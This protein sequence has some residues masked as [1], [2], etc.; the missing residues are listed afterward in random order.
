MPVEIEN[1]PLILVWSRN[2]DGTYDMF[3]VPIFQVHTRFEEVF[4][5]D[6]LDLI[7][8]NSSTRRRAVNAKV[9]CCH[10]SFFGDG[11]TTQNVGLLRN[12]ERQFG[13]VLADFVNVRAAAFRAIVKVAYVQRSVELDPTDMNAIEG[14]ALLGKEQPFFPFRDIGVELTEEQETQLDADV[15]D[16]TSFQWGRAKVE[17]HALYAAGET[18]MRNY[19]G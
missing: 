3:H 9:F 8:E 7:V 2:E 1:G 10:N 6:R 16:D 17:S 14:I 11:G 19:Y 12:L 4:D 18:M 13:V 5:E 15:E